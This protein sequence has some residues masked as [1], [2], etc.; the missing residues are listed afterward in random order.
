MRLMFTDAEIAKLV[1]LAESRA[2]PVA[3]VAYELIERALRR[4][5]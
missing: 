3:T 1:R 4:A 5:K 2:L